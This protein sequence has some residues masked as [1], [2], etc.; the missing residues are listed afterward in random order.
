MRAN[1]SSHL[2]NLLS[3]KIIDN[4]KE[5]SIIREVQSIAG[6]YPVRSEVNILSFFEYINKLDILLCLPR[7]YHNKIEFIRWKPGDKLK[8]NN[9]LYEPHKI[10]EVIEPELLIVP[11][12]GFDVNC[13]RIGYGKGFYDNYIRNNKSAITIGVAFSYQEVT[14]GIAVDEYDEKLNY[15]VTEDKII[16]GT[17]NSICWD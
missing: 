15:I 1:I 14:E 4:I 5:L 16:K 7:I 6:Y 8:K 12:L 2:R 10:T 9:H 17:V 3:N 13:N 11:L